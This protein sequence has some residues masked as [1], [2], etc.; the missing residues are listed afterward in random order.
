MLKHLV[1]THLLYNPILQNA[2]NRKT[3]KVTKFQASTINGS[4]VILKNPIAGARVNA[5]D[6]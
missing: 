5:L 3:L 4:R 6:Y 2:T 1:I